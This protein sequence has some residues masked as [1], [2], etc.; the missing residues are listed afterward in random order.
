MEMLRRVHDHFSSTSDL[1]L[2]LSNGSHESGQ[3]GVDAE[4]NVGA[5]IKRVHNGKDQ[6][7]DGARVM[8]RILFILNGLLNES[9]AE[10]MR[11]GLRA[12]NMKSGG[13][14]IRFKI[15][16]KGKNKLIECSELCLERMG[17]VTQLLASLDSCIVYPGAT[18]DDVRVYCRGKELTASAHKSKSFKE[19][20]F[21]SIETLLVVEKANKTLK[22]GHE[23]LKTPA[24][25]LP[26]GILS[27]NKKYFDL[28]FALI[29]AVPTPLVDSLWSLLMR[30]PTSREHLHAVSICGA[31]ADTAEPETHQYLKTSLGM[32]GEGVYVPRLVYA[33][34]IID[35]FISAPHLFPHEIPNG[36]IL[37]WFQKFVSF[38]GI[39]ILVQALAL[40]SGKLSSN[41]GHDA[42]ETAK[43][44]IFLLI[45]AVHGLVK[46]LATICE[47]GFA[48][49]AENGLLQYVEASN[50]RMAYLTGRPIKTN[51]DEKQN[52]ISKAT[53]KAVGVNV[54]DMFTEEPTSLA[55]SSNASI[56][57]LLESKGWS[58]GASRV[59]DHVSISTLAATQTASLACIEAMHL[60]SLYQA[61]NLPA[62]VPN[63]IL[64][65]VEFAANIV[66]TALMVWV[67]CIQQSP[68]VINHL[69]ED[70]SRTE[71]P[72]FRFLSSIFSM[73]SV[74]F[75]TEAVPDSLVRGA[76]MFGTWFVGAI[77]DV[78]RVIK[79]LN[80]A[81]FLRAL[82]HLVVICFQLRPKL[83]DSN[84]ATS[85]DFHQLTLLISLLRDF[86]G[87]DISNQVAFQCHEAGIEITNELVVCYSR[88]HF[89]KALNVSDKLIAG[90]LGL[91]CEAVRCDDTLMPALAEEGLEDLLL[92]GCLG[93]TSVDELMHPVVCDGDES[94]CL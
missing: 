53:N 18:I 61:I 10:A 65:D 84:I 74:R 93:L 51:L 71:M 32:H 25:L 44:S 67:L 38:G 91:L 33:V 60:F 29:D 39:D 85:I 49:T 19:L 42:V 26:A 1:V 40:V 69:F 68:D 80:S 16:F 3:H 62:S 28:F 56:H 82:D 73:G 14:I 4:Y 7:F 79:H 30:L 72:L 78:L 92:G 88:V 41:C 55:P 23:I 90:N 17:Q 76:N 2:L 52:A 64:W 77:M 50:T 54:D 63:S 45:Q 37:S 11:A 27:S 13:D 9:A 36:D 43:E 47:L 8:M 86:K 5:F 35:S 58:Q 21:G 70:P 22:E 48:F 81:H 31:A 59:L 15:D 34:Q 46:V 66:E 57:V 6:T 12:H 94:R 20:Q 24:E 89:V 83:T 75:N 87:S